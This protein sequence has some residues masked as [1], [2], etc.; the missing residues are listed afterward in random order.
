MPSLHERDGTLVAVD[1]SGITIADIT[2]EPGRDG[3]GSLH[4]ADDH[5]DIDEFVAGRVVLIDH[6]AD[7]D[8]GG[9]ILQ[10]PAAD[11]S[12]G[13][14]VTVW[15][16]IGMDGLLGTSRS[17]AGFVK[18]DADGTGDVVYGW[19]AR[20]WDDSG[21]ADTPTS[22]GTFGQPAPGM[23]TPPPQW[24][25]KY[26]EWLEG[27][28]WGRAALSFAADGVTLWAAGRVQVWL[29]GEEVADT[30]ADGVAA[31]ATIDVA[32]GQVLAVQVSDGRKGGACITQDVDGDAEVLWRTSTGAPYS[33]ATA[34]SQRVAIAAESPPYPWGSDYP[35]TGGSTLQ[36][37]WELTVPGYGTTAA[38]QWDTTAAA[39]QSALNAV[40]G[41]TCT[42]TGDDPWTV[43]FAAAMGDVGSMGITHSDLRHDHA[44]TG[45]TTTTPGKATWAAK[46]ATDWAVTTTEPDGVTFGYVAGEVDAEMDGRGLWAGI[47]LHPT[48]TALVDAD[49]TAWA[50]SLPFVA[51]SRG[52]AGDLLRAAGQAFAC[53]H[54]L[55]PSWQLAGR[56]AGVDR[57]GTVDLDGVVVAADIEPARGPTVTHVWVEVDGNAGWIPTGVAGP[58]VEAHATFGQARTLREITQAAIEVAAAQR[59]PWT[60]TLEMASG[61]TPRPSTNFRAADLVAYGVRTV[62]VLQVTSTPPTRDFAGWRY[63][64]EVEDAA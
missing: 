1:W 51:F 10:D 21:W 55:D 32:A 18:G 23:P 38:I 50:V 48:M 46:P 25:D 6:E 12:D 16:G 11:L 35:S 3:H 17:L 61:R 54:L 47:T 60:A 13:P 52:Q 64:V 40:A 63:T 8:I 43:T 29:D 44:Q 28:L 9:F 36:G 49:G 26:T 59:S 39:V 20:S 2:D 7:G 5:P 45:V 30:T 53:W 14:P 62:K 42:V 56:Q 58:R 41:V 24:P 37:T 57:T 27:P 22:G 19:V 34:E 31:R 33:V 15:S 4:L